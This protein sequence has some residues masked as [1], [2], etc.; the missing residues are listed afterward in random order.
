VSICTLAARATFAARA[1][2][3]DSASRCEGERNE[4][5]DTTVYAM[6]TL[7]GLISMGM[8][9]NKK[10]EALGATACKGMAAR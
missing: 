8:Q 1:R 5:L 7:H 2:V 3:T 4:V 9:L 6:V 10:A